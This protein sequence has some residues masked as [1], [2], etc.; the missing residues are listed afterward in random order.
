MNPLINVTFAL[1]FFV[2]SAPLIKAAEALP[3]LLTIDAR[4]VKWE[5]RPRDPAVAPDGQVWFCGQSENYIARLNPDTGEMKRYKVPEGSYPHNLTID[6]SGFVW[7][8]GNKNGHIG[9]LDPETG[10]IQRFDMPESIKD[11]H[12]LVFDAEENIWFTAQWSN[13]VGHLNT[14]TGKVRYA[15][16]SEAKSRPYGIKLNDKGQ[17][18]VVMVGTHKIASVD[19]DSFSLNEI[20][21]PDEGARPRR[22]QVLD[23]QVWFVD[24]ANG[25]LGRYSPQNNSFSFWILPHGANS[26]P[27]GTAL[28]KHKNLWIAETGIYPNFIVG[29][30]TQKESFFSS[31][32]LKQG[33]SVRYMHYDK[34]ADKF[35]FGVDTGFIASAKLK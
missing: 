19:I 16:A 31:N 24:Y 33:G 4:F 14:K 25:Q 32:K 22:L 26:K 11:P 5:G 12:T 28:D 17:P 10:D 27:Y 3:A 9:K 2:S 29:F 8:A 20:A 18:W 23:N 30:D 13:A 21:L 34:T 15:I 7:Y 1:I 6:K 35:W